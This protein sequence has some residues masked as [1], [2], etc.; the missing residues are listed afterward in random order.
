M[1]DPT[2][3]TQNILTT[4]RISDVKR[5]QGFFKIECVFLQLPL[6]KLNVC[7]QQ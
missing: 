3:A 2:M 7:V 5:I 4:I 1:L 6:L